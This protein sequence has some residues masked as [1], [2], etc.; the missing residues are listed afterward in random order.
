MLGV[1]YPLKELEYPEEE[2]VREWMGKIRKNT[3][4]KVKKA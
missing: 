1:D 2:A 4:I 3:K